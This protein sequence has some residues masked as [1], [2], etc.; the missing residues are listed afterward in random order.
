MLMWDV[1][2]ADFETPFLQC[3]ACMLHADA[4]IRAVQLFGI[5][6]SVR[7]YSV[8]RVRE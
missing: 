6:V 8:L 5:L 7:T 1:A 3:A 4:R 2:L